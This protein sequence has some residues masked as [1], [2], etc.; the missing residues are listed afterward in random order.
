MESFTT[1]ID[2]I[3]QNK[4]SIQTRIHITTIVGSPGDAEFEL[5]T[6]HLQLTTMSDTLNSDYYHFSSFLL[7]YSGF[8]NCPN[9]SMFCT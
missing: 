7:I 2:I 1:A 4:G 3:N 8:Q 6:H 5:S 9:V